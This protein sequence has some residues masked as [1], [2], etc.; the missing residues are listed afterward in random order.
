MKV[1]YSELKKLLPDLNYPAKKIADDLTLIG[2]LSEGVDKTDG[3]E[4][5]NLEI[6]KDR[7][8]AL[9]YLGLAKDLS[10]FYN[11]NLNNQKGKEPTVNSKQLPGIK[12]TAKK[13]VHRLMSLKITNIENK[14]S[15]DWLKNFLQLHEINPINVL[16]DLTNYVMLIYGIPCHAFDA[17]KV[18]N[19]LEWKIAETKEK[20]TTLDGTEIDIPT[21]SLVITDPEGTASLSTIGGQRTSIDLNTTET[22]IEMAIYN[23]TRVRLDSKNMGI[24]TEASI[25]LEKELDTELIPTAFNYLIQLILDNC[26]GKI[27]SETFDFYPKKP[28][29]PSIEFYPEKPAEFAGVNI[30][31]KFSLGTLKKLDCQVSQSGTTYQVI[32]P[33]LRKDLCLK[34]DLIEEVIR[35]YGYNKIP[36]DQPI[37][38]DKLPDITPKILYLIQA[39]KNTLVNF[40]YDEIR[41][42]PIIR[43]SNLHKPNYLPKDA[44]PIYTENNVNSEYPLLRMS[45]A[46]S[47][48]LQTIQSKKLKLP[49][50]QF[51]E[52]GKIY[53]QLNRKYLENYSVSLY[54]PNDKLLKKDTEKL[55]NKLNGEGDYS[56]EK[57]NGKTFV[58][59]NL[60]KLV[61]ALSEIPE[62]SLD[63]PQVQTSSAV[64][65][66]R[67]IIDLDA[68]VIIDHKINPQKLINKYQQKIPSDHLW[69]LEITDIYRTD[70]KKFKYTIR[71][72]YYN[73]TAAKAK[74]IHKT[75]FELA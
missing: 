20:I 18:S 7:G 9:S 47:L 41:S 72:Y 61:S 52:I 8:D 25:R 23:P 36:A 39:V 45:L 67:Q 12:I 2:H 53:Y 59:I 49:D 69:K 58:E 24:I 10:V 73:I 70:D 43:E 40:G 29:T 74:E 75:A 27:A 33:T 26:G 56:V 31:E 65:L 1:I 48:N 16:V 13:S 37:S 51:F 5:I 11:L 46:S 62:I 68:N 22:I 4:V 57:I 28:E 14:T 6:A 32:P 54:H 3:E 19:Q 63:T 34:E 42:W 35:F 44:K 60:D 66:T 71:A 17:Q 38:S 21:G 30:P 50:R 55:L 64:E 15:P